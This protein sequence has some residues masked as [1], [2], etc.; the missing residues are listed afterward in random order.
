MTRR[1]SPADLADI[2]RDT[3][4]AQTKPQRT[5][6][7]DILVQLLKALAAGVGA[8]ML[9]GG[10][11]WLL[12]APP[13][14]LVNAAATTAVIVTGVVLLVQAVPSDKLLTVRRIQKVQAVVIDAEFRKRKAYQAIEQL[15]AQ[16]AEVGRE[17][18]RALA[19]LRNENKVLRAELLRYKE[20]GRTV[21]F[22]PRSKIAAEIVKDAETI[23]E[24]WFATLRP[25]SRGEMVGEWWSRPKAV[26]AGWTKTRHQDASKLLLDAGVSGINE[27]LPH[28]LPTFADAGAALYRLHTYCE[29]ASREP[30]MP[31]RQEPYVDMD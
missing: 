1:L 18:Q 24:H 31:R 9:I 16:H 23:I 2:L 22:V 7:G 8:A 25:N 19:E 13:D 5:T 14:F 6:A 20:A 11:L 26:A 15:E 29:Q 3:T 21:A 28:I 27:K 12:G 17:W 30:D 10:A 4:H